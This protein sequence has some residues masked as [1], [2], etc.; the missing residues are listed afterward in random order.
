[1]S[2]AASLIAPGTRARPWEPGS[3]EGP[4]PLRAGG[5]PAGR[6]SRRRER[7][8][9]D[10]GFT[11]VELLVAAVAAVAV[12]SATLHVLASTQQV[13]ARDSE[14]A[15]GI[16]E[17]RAGLARMVRDIRQAT[18]IVEP[19]TGAPSGSIVFWATLGG[20]KWKI[21]YDCG[22]AQ[23]GSSYDECVRLA[24]EDGS[25]LP[26][27]GPRIATDITNG[28][29]VFSY[30]PTTRTEAKLAIVKLEL[31]AKG[32]L[33]QAGSS[34]YGHKVVLEDGAFMRN[35]YPEG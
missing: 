11:L 32:T 27:T 25:A 28:A 19:S 17:D 13:Q 29:S 22:V 3:K 33:K 10:S 18:E 24:A 8:L 26:S 14:W 16:Q 23:P 12:V 1:M 30:S 21:K 2:T 31:P 20:K 35:L 5:S 7:L 34:G 4:A 9:D 6:N 15:L